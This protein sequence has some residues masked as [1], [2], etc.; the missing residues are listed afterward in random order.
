MKVPV[1]DTKKT[2]KVRKVEVLKRPFFTELGNKDDPS[3]HYHATHPPQ[4]DF[5]KGGKSGLYSCT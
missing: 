2:E 1:S 3:L 4:L 5:T